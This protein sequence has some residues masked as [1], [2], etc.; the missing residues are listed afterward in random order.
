MAATPGFL[1]APGMVPGPLV[2]ML[3]VDPVRNFAPPAQRTSPRPPIPPTDA[4]GRTNSS[5]SVTL[6][7][8]EEG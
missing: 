1:G 4:D 8:L 3:S 7:D 5:D 2:E 6:A